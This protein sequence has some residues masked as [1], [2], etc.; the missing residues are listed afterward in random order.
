MF[1]PAYAQAGD[2]AG[3]PSAL[4]Q[5]LPFI[6]I[7][8]IF[9][10]F[11]IRPQQKRVKEHRDMLAALRRGD[12]VVTSGGLIAK[13]TRVSEDEDEVEAEISDGVKVRVMKPTIAQVISKTEPAKGGSVKAPDSKSKATGGRI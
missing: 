4:L 12:E 2:A 1:T 13:I 8:V 5:F 3:G 11:I 9:Y 6:L 7:F 10:F